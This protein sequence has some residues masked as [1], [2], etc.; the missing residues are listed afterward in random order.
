MTVAALL[1]ATGGGVAQG[2]LAWSRGTDVPG[3]M[4]GA[5]VLSAGVSTLVALL[6]LAAAALALAP[7][8]D[9]LVEVRVAA[10]E[11]DEAQ[12]APGPQQLIGRVEGGQVPMAVGENPDDVLAHGP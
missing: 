5:L 3:W 12:G 9:P 7:P 1:R 8:E 2:L 6:G 11:E 4:L 10:S